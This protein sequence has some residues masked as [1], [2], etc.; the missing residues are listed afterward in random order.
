MYTHIKDLRSA[1]LPKSLAD[2]YDRARTGASPE[3][4]E[5]RF[6]CNVML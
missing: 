4:D 5:A 6:M 3:L 1:S 2:A